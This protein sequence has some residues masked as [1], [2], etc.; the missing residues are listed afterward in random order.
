MPRRSIAAIAAVLLAVFGAVVII[1]Y[2]RGADTR[3]QAGEQL[4]DVLVVDSDV[5]AGT[6]VGDLGG[7]VSIQ[8]VPE[9]L[10]APGAVADL[11]ELADQVSIAALVPG[12]QVVSPRF[13]APQ[14]LAPEG[15]VPAPA[16]TVEVS[17]SLDAQRAVGGVLKAGDLVGVQLVQQD[18]PV[19]SAGVEPLAGVPVTRVLA[20]AAADDPNAVF[21][22]TLALTPDQAKQFVVG[23]SAQGVWLSLEKAAPVSASDSRVE[24][25]ITAPLGD[26]K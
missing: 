13:A 11:S 4:V 19:G 18:A 26:T 5:A 2:V 20:P 16:G 10:L 1:S 23:S 21:L 15:T 7:S 25:T 3:A 24:T 6:S 9:R 12:D 8:R 14:D 17:V 22:I